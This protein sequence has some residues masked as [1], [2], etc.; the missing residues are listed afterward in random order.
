VLPFQEYELHAVAL[1]LD[2]V[3]LLMVSNKVAVESHPPAFKV[4]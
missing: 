4:V 2:V 3:L 1:V